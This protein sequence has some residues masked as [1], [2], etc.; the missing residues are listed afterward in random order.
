MKEIKVREESI[1]M[2][3]SPAPMESCFLGG[4]TSTLILEFITM[5]GVLHIDFCFDRSGKHSL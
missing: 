5:S 4:L 3:K 1:M 2:P